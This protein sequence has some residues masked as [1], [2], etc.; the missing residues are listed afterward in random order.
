MT[1]TENRSRFLATT[2]DVL[3]PARRT[4]PTGEQIFHCVCRPNC[5][6]FCP[7]DVYVR[8]GYVVKSRFAEQPNPE[9]NRICLRGLSNL[10]RLHNPDRIK[11]P[12]MRVGERGENKWR[13]ISWDEAITRITDQW[14]KDIAEYG[15]ESISF[16]GGTAGHTLFHGTLP[17]MMPRL[18]NAMGA[19]NLENS[20][21]QAF[22]TGYSRVAGFLDGNGPRDWRNAKTIIIDGYNVTEANIHNWHFVADAQ[23]GGTK[24]IVIDPVYTHAASKADQYIPCRPASDSALILGL[25]YCIVRD[26]KHNVPFLQEHTVAPYLVRDDTHEFLRMKDVMGDDDDRPVVVDKNNNF[27]P[28]DEA[29]DPEINGHYTLSGF[30]KLKGLK[31]ATAFQLLRERLDEYPV[32]LVSELTEIPADVIEGLAEDFCSGPTTLVTGWGVQAYNNGTE[33]GRTWATLAAITGNIAKP[34]CEVASFWGVYPGVN[35]GFMMPDGKMGKTLPIV[36]MPEIM[37]T[38]MALNREY[39]IKSLYVYQGNIVGNTVDQRDWLDRVVPNMDLIVTCDLAFTDT[40]RYSDIIL[41]AAHYYEEEEII[42]ALGNQ[43]WVQFSEK[44]IDP[45]FEA[46]A[47]GDIARLL[48]DAMGVGEYFAKTDEE[49]MNEA[50]DTPMSHSLGLNYASLKEKKS[51][52]VQPDQWLAYGGK[53][54]FPTADGRLHFYDEHPAPRIDYGQEIPVERERLPMFFPPNEAWPGTKAQTEYPLILL[55]ERPRFRV[56]SMWF[57]TPWLR[58]LDPEPIIKI[59]PKDAEPRGIHDGDLVEAYNSRGHAVAKAVLTKGIRPGCLTYPKGWQRHQH[60]AGSFSELNSN[61]VDPIGV[62]MNFFD[63]TVDIRP[64]QEEK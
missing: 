59:N 43:P 6:G 20:L 12:M 4:A 40:A 54:Q 18:T 8:D 14:K 39:P 3:R 47:D 55:S 15:P 29:K 34:G 38:G 33:C 19:T 63:A 9:Y 36:K 49:L 32:E 10:Q 28:L 11:Y 24:V 31:V 1:T 22:S 27:V 64:W 17:G 50:L 48:A 61:Y 57:D 44:A 5:G 7:H 53:P 25:M 62:N 42:S 2:D 26:N 56:H 13:R 52:Q 46:K 37:G 41:P 21:D 30:K 23:D 35:F 45:L 60:V 51:I 58:E 16:Y